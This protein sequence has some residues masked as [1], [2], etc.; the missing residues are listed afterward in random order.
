[1][2]RYS[3]KVYPRVCLYGQFHLDQGSGS[4]GPTSYRYFY[5]CMYPGNVWP[6]STHFHWQGQTVLWVVLYTNTWSELTWVKIHYN[7]KVCLCMYDFTCA[8]SQTIQIIRLFPSVRPFTKSL[9]YIEWVWTFVPS[10]CLGLFSACLAQGLKKTSVCTG[11][12]LK[13]G[14]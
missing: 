2:V 3:Q 10:A 5:V 9:L 4:V 13:T 6:R 1:M 14:N 7:Q 8:L 12:T 11:R